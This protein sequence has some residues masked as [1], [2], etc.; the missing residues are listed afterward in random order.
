MTEAQLLQTLSALTAL[1]IVYKLAYL[2]RQSAPL[3]PFLAR[4]FRILAV[5]LGTLITY[6]AAITVQSTQVPHVLDILINLAWCAVLAAIIV[7]LG[8]SRH[9]W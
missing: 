8:R 9:V 5:M 4:P 7:M 2:V 6:R 3:P 1:C